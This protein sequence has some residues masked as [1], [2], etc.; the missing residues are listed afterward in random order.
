[1]PGLVCD[2]IELDALIR[3]RQETGADRDDE[4]WEGLYVMSPL[5]TPE[6]QRIAFELSAILIEVVTRKKLGIVYGSS[7]VTDQEFDWTHHYRCR[8]VVMVL[9]ESAHRYRDIGPT[10][11]G[12][13]DFLIEVR[14]PEDKTF[15]KLD[16]YASI[17]VRELLVVD[18][19]TK[20]LRLFRLNA[21]RLL[22]RSS[23]D[24]WFA[25]EVVPLRF[26]TTSDQEVEVCSTEQPPRVWLV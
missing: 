17:G 4:V 20:A 9:K 1:M 15:E 6:H 23:T 14:S 8:D 19:D 12:G 24:G 21:G 16:F 13:P 7:N 25:S 2:P 3:R 22:E 18:R 11:L 26:L 5:A 10:L